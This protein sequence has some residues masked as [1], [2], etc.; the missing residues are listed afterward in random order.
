MKSDYSLNI[1][2]GEEEVLSDMM[3]D[4]VDVLPQYYKIG[5]M[6]GL[7][8]NT[9]EKIKE[10]RLDSFEAMTLIIKH[11]FN[12]D[13]RGHKRLTWKSLVEAVAHKN[14]GNNVALAMKLTDNHRARGKGSCYL[15]SY[16]NH[17]V[18]VCMYVCVCVCV[19]W[20]G[21]NCS[22]TLCHNK[23]VTATQ[24]NLTPSILCFKLLSVS[25]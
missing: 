16:K 17:L 22:H 2:T 6:L 13:V 21:I 9:L 14:G 8:M 15:N 11:W 19:W 24:K 3:K 18:C 1:Y 7:Q 4:L 10:E 5:K 23:G 12:D 25:P 20:G